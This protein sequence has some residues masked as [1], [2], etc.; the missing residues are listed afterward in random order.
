MQ[1]SKL[2]FD[3][4]EHFEGVKLNAYLDSA[5]IATIGIGTTVYPSG[6]PVKMGDKCTVDQ[7]YEYLKHHV[8]KNVKIEG[9][10]RQHEYD[11]ILSLVYNIGQWAFNK[12]TL[13]KIIDAKRTDENSIYNAFLMWNKASVKGVK[14][15]IDGLTRRRKSEAFL[16]INGYNHATFFE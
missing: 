15:E 5:S 3:L 16:F 2:F 14:I 9:E 11:A 6:L 8:A 7:A 4:V 1:P 10:F 12:S 13:K